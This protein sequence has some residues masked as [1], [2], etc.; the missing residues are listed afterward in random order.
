MFRKELDIYIPSLNVAFEYN[1]MIWHSEMFGKDKNYHLNK[2]L[3]CLRQGIRL[4]HIYEYEWLNNKIAVQ[5]NI[6]QIL[7]NTVNYSANTNIS[8]KIFLIEEN[9]AEEFLKQYDVQGFIN[10]DLYV[11]AFIEEKLVSVMSLKKGNK[12]NELE[13]TRFIVKGY[14]NVKEI[15]RKT[16]QWFVENYKPHIVTITLDR[17]WNSGELIEELGFQLIET[18][19]PTF[20]YTR[21]PNEYLTA[22]NIIRDGFYKIWNCGYFKYQWKSCDFI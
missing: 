14:S 2:T 9:K 5:N 7:N 17:R 20:A 15:H 10:S 16:F 13:I 8:S 4:Y 19:P 11:G 18:L 22:I 3:D 12:E 1:G 6:L 21:S